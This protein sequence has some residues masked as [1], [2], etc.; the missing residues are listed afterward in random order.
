MLNDV[1]L[2]GVKIDDK[3]QWSYQ[4]KQLKA[5]ALKALDLVK[6]AKKFLPLSY[7]QKIYRGTVD[8]HFSYCCSI[9]GC[10][11]ESKL[12]SLQKIQKRATRIVTNNPYCAPAAPLLQ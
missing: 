6:H 9:L 10:G 8:L 4:V 1:T 11:G 2:L 7:L 5:M 12:N 3:L